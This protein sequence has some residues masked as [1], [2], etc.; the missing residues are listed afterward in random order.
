MIR[1][2]EINGILPHRHGCTHAPACL[3]GVAKRETRTNSTMK[4]M[5]KNFFAVF[6]G[7]EMLAQSTTPL[8]LVALCLSSSVYCFADEPTCSYGEDGKPDTCAFES[9]DL[10]EVWLRAPW[11]VCSPLDRHQWYSWLSVQIDGTIPG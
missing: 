2:A 3:H 9:G 1:H 8:V 5:A 6:S 10:Y 11:A 7:A 4:R